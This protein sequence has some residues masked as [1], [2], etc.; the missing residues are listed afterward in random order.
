MGEGE[1]KLWAWVGE[2][3]GKLWALPCTRPSDCNVP[4]LQIRSSSGSLHL[5]DTAVLVSLAQAGGPLLWPQSCGAGHHLCLAGATAGRLD[6]Y[7]L[8]DDLHSGDG[9]AEGQL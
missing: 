8:N 7:V 5:H 6:L 2:R 3:E 4:Q 9:N 1:G